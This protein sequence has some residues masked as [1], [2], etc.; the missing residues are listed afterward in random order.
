MVPVEMLAK[1]GHMFESPSRSK[2]TELKPRTMS[3]QTTVKSPSRTIQL[4]QPIT[5]AYS[6]QSMLSHVVE[7]Q[8]ESTPHRKR[9]PYGHKKPSPNRQ[10]RGRSP[11]NSPQHGGR[12][13]NKEFSSP[14]RDITN[15]VPQTPQSIG[16]S[17]G[18]RMTLAAMP[19][20]ENAPKATKQVTF[21]SRLPPPRVRVAKPADHTESTNSAN[22]AA[23]YSLKT[24]LRFAKASRVCFE[25]T[26]AYGKPLIFF[27]GTH[28]RQDPN[29]S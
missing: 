25:Q 18:R 9:S 15:N 20:T 28:K 5:P 3:P 1:F 29:T 17:P 24:G 22:P 27:L 4:G 11:R 21:E 14:I 23:P 7:P 26:H 6:F 10:G 12:N 16:K 13:N 19:R 8:Q 2:T